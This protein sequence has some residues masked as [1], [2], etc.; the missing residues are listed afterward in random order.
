MTYAA[1]DASVH[2]GEPHELYEV[3]SPSTEYRF[4]FHPTDLSYDSSAFS[5]L[6]GTQ[7][8]T[9]IPG[10]RGGLIHGKSG[11]EEL[12]C[13]LPA[14][15]QLCQDYAFRSALA[16]RTLTVA[17]YRRHGSTG[18]ASR[19]WKGRVHGFAA[20]GA[21]VT[22][23]SVSP[24]KASLQVALPRQGALATCQ[25]AFGDVRCGITPDSFTTTIDAID[26][27]TITL[28]DDGGNPDQWARFG[29]AVHTLT[30]EQRF[31]EDHTGNVLTLLE[32]FPEAS[33]TDEVEI[34]QGC[35]RSIDT[36]VDTFDNVLNFFGPGVHMT[37]RNPHRYG[38]MRA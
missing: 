5:G 24:A 20:R 37:G 6:V 18:T 32:A 31:I 34:F 9:A 25:H 33:V 13:E 12:A 1:D 28:D 21:L 16:Q 2:G 29:V 38:W 22:L 26:G 4:T 35:D 14:S 36:C 10:Y 23:R 11:A 7:T 3:V 19:I 8:Y 15:H 30:G 27:A 17:A